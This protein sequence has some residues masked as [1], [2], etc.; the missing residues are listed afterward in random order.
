METLTEKLLLKHENTSR[1]DKKITIICETVD[2]INKKFDMIDEKFNIFEAK[3]D[4][5]QRSFS[6][7]IALTSIIITIIV[8]LIQYFGK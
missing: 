1:L 4:K 6:R 3:L 5:L 8:A 2:I 7:K